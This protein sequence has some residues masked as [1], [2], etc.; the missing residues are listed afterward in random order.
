MTTTVYNNAFEWRFEFPE[1][2]DNE[3][4]FQGFDVICTFP[5]HHKI[6]TNKSLRLI[7]KNKFVIYNSQAPTYL[8]FF[9]LALTLLKP[10]GITSLL[11]AQKFETAQYG[12]KLRTLL[13]HHHI[14]N[15]NAFSANYPAPKLQNIIIKK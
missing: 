8:Y 2:L 9:E 14:L 7:Y 15:R 13:T 10:S 5:P 4:N 12:L 6:T 1:I 11:T 3:G